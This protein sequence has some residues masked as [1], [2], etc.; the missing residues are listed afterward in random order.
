MCILCNALRY[1]KNIYSGFYAM[2]QDTKKNIYSGFP[3]RF[4]DMIPE[5]DSV[6][7]GELGQETASLEVVADRRSNPGL[8]RLIESDS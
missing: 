3:F 7:V 2:H 1:K 6:S 5:D 4:F 8:N